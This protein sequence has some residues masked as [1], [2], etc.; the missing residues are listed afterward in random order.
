[1]TKKEHIKI[2]LRDA[3]KQF[4][5]DTVDL[6]QVKFDLFEIADILGIKA[7]EITIGLGLDIEDE[8]SR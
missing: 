5:F 4:Q 3:I 6:A 2:H 7:T 1:M 8:Y